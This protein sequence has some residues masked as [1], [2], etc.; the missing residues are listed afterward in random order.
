M[1]EQCCVEN[2]TGY[3][4][5]INITGF[6]SD[7]HSVQLCLI[8]TYRVSI[9]AHQFEHYLQWHSI[10][11]KHMWKSYFYRNMEILFFYSSF[12]LFMLLYIFYWA[13]SWC[14]LSFGTVPFF[15]S[16]CLIFYRN[17]EILFLF[18]SIFSF[19]HFS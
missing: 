9:R 7:Q 14:W 15:C 12:L 1:V 4:R 6:F 3:F 18:D 17:M 8:H 13:F 19:S 5:S 11:L 16:C 2:I 10:A